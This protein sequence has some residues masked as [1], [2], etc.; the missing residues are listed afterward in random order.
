MPH[1]LYVRS[2]R[3]LRRGGFRTPRLDV[4]APPRS[5]A[6]SKSERPASPSRRTGRLDKP[7]SDLAHPTAPRFERRRPGQLSILL[8]GP[9]SSAASPDM[10]YRRAQCEPRACSQWAFSFSLFLSRSR[11]AVSDRLVLLPPSL[12][13]PAEHGGGPGA[14]TRPI[15]LVSRHR[16]A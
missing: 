14:A 16:D 10:S 1:P 7:P 8:S 3:D 9:R 13:S 11:S 15:L 2:F 6:R 5:S 12:E 4:R